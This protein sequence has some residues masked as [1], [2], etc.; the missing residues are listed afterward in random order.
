M[1]DEELLDIL[2]ETADDQFVDGE[3]VPRK[4]SEVIS[5]A[6]LTQNTTAILLLSMPMNRD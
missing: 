3:K 2:E 5:K 4:Y 6:N 1:L